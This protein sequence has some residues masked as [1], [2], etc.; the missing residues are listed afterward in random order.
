[1]YGIGNQR[2]LNYQRNELKF[3]EHR[4]V[5]ATYMA[6]VEVFD[7]RKLHRA[8]A[9]TDAKNENEEIIRKYA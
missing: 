3:S 2:L 5:T 4:L 6:E 7:P 1:V 8:L 9:Y